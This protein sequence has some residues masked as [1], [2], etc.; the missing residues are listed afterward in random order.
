MA[1]KLKIS[2]F[3][4]FVATL[5]PLTILLGQLVAIASPTEITSNYFTS[6]RN[7]FNVLFV[8]KGWLWTSV[9]YFLLLA[10]VPATS[11]YANAS[12]LQ[13]S[14][15]QYVCATAWWI[16]Y[17]QWFFGLPIMD[18]VFIL[19]GGQCSGISPAAAIDTS[20]FK[21]MSSNLDELLYSSSSIT[22]A[23]CRA[24][25]GRWHGGHDPSGHVFILSLSSMLLILECARFYSLQDLQ[26]EWARFKQSTARF[27]ETRSLQTATPLL[28]DYPLV[29]IAL[30]LVLWFWM[31]FVTSMH[32][33][34][35]VE[36]LAG[37]AF[38]YLGIYASIRLF[39]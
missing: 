10:R 25:K 35:F 7:I 16:F 28:K 17:S 27:W 26:T 19:T 21:V 4:A 29:Y 1:R 9:V 8:K 24:I 11:R 18:K 23:K 20:K 12:S 13:Q 30:L 31:L 6:K 39:Q 14:L 34:S 36:K 2:K 5:Y 15:K 33:H 22:S 3:Q 37:L 38:S 32:F